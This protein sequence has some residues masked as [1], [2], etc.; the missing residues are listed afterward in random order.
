MMNY[1]FVYGTLMKGHGNNV[2]LKD[3]KYVCKVETVKKF[4]MSVNTIPFLNRLPHRHIK[5]ELYEVS[6]VILREVD[7]LEGHPDFYI[8]EKIEVICNNIIF[9]NVYCYFH[10]GL[11]G[12][13]N[14]S[15]DFNNIDLME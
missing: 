9:S 11:G 4:A 14:R 3:T 12:R 2:I 1:L 7:E 15:G 13:L 6:D 5:G 8:R 10:Y